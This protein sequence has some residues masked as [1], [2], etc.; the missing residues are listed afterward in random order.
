[1]NRFYRKYRTVGN[2]I[3]IGLMIAV[4][5]PLL[6]LA[7]YNHPSAADDYCYIDTVF[8]IGWFEAMKLYYTTWTG[9]Y[10]GI[11]LN[12]SNP[13]LFHS[14]TGFKVLPVVLIAATIFALYSLFRHLTPTLSRVA[15]LGFAGVV[16]FLFVLKM[17]SLAEAF[18]WMAAFVTYSVPNMLTLFWIV[19]VL[20]WYRQDTQSAK[21]LVGFLAGFLVFAVIG[22]SEQNMLTMVL[23][24]GAWWVYRLIYYR[25]VDA[26][27]VSMLVITGISCYLLLGSPGNQARMGGNPLGGNIPFSTISTLKKLAILGFDW[28]F[29]TPLIFFTAVWLVVMSRLSEG[30]RNY[31]SIP[32]WY[33]VLLFIGVLSA[34]LF[35]SYYGVGIEPTHRVVN[36]AYFFFLIGWF[37]IWGVIFHY[38]KQKRFGF[39]QF[40]VARFVGL[41][42]IL[43]ASVA[44]SFYRSPNVRLVY[45]DW[46]KGKA[47]AYDKEM[48]QRYALMK[49]ST[50]EVTYLPPIHSKAFSIYVEDDITA[51]Q[52]HWWNKCM[53][54]YYGKKAIIMSEKNE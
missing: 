36:S 7:Y 50:E 10:S 35:P 5:V 47:A 30:A 8:K 38:F 33:A 49:N 40:T 29:R 26:F 3:N 24:V 20:R 9:R 19:M 52:D 31:F 48:Y 2:W 28:V 22:A 43:L 54:G 51:N 41:Y 46:L 27:M 11:F 25:K 23:L 44:L 6:A 39:F 12:H 45:T 15:H 14:I 17:A 1:M 42:V 21:F 34:Q 16:F 18:Y 13:L 37:Y 32:V 4:L 53:A